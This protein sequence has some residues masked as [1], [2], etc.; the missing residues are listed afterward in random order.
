MSR[1]PSFRPHWPLPILIILILPLLLYRLAEVPHPWYDEGLNLTSARTMAETGLIALPSAGV[2]RVAD[3]AIQTGAPLLVPQSYWYTLVRSNLGLT[4]L[5]M[6][7]TSVL[8]L[9]LIYTLAYRL[10]GQPAALIAV[11]L[12]VAMPGSEPTGTY[13]MMSRQTLG[14]LPAILCLALVFNLLLQKR[15]GALC[16]VLVGCLLGLAVV[17]KSQVLVV[18]VPTIGLF[19]V[20]RMAQGQPDWWRWLLIAGIMGLIF[21]L[22]ILWRSTMA[23]PLWPANLDTLREGAL[24][25]I[26]PFRGLQNLQ[27]PRLLARFILGLLLVAGVYLFQR[28]YPAQIPAAPNARAVQTLLLLLVAL[29]M[30]WYGL[31]SIGWSRYAIIGQT[32]MMIFAAYLV[33]AGLRRWT[34]WRWANAVIVALAVAAAF[35]FQGPRLLNETTG[36]DFYR[37]ADYLRQTLTPQDRVITW[38]WPMSYITDYRY[39]YP[40]TH[41]ANRITAD[42]FVEHAP[43]NPPDFDALASCPN[44]L[45]FGSFLVDRTVLA[46]ARAAADPTPVFEQGVYQLYR[47]PEQNLEHHPDGTCGLKRSS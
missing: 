4:R 33:A 16:T 15:A 42:L 25:H 7:V 41:F 44:Y 5:P 13:L 28:R 24:I 14:E 45:L 34:A 35:T 17:L 26:I 21:G 27:E 3:P 11:G 39:I 37:M 43:Y 47:I 19:T 22:D 18:I 6:V 30:V 2:L 46:E 32:F 36:S 1:L 38:E 20:H 29:W 31:I 12:I 10:Y 9:I 40:P 23:G 8:A